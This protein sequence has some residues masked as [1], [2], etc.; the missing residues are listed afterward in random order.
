MKALDRLNKT[1]KGKTFIETLVMYTEWTFQKKWWMPTAIALFLVTGS[2]SIRVHSNLIFGIGSAVFIFMWAIPIFI[3]AVQ[4]VEGTIPEYIERIVTWK[5]A[6][7]TLLIIECIYLLRACLQERIG[8][9]IFYVFLMLGTSFFLWIESRRE[10][11]Q[12]REIK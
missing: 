4:T 1:L 6:F 2:L 5:N 12:K 11:R 8:K 9:A 10:S 3:F 7:A